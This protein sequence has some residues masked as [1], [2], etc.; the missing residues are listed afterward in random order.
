MFI[1]EFDDISSIKIKYETDNNGLL[2]YIFPIIYENEGS[3]FGNVTDY[4]Y[5]S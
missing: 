1:I 4:T 3:L 5:Q 2:N